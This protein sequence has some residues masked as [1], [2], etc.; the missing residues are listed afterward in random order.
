MPEKAK[1]SAKK[2]RFNGTP[3][4]TLLLPSLSGY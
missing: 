1:L 2:H 3:Q 4:K